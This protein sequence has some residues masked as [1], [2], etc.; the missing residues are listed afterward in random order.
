MSVKPVLL[1]HPVRLVLPDRPVQPDHP[2][3]LVLPD[4]P[5][6]LVQPDLKGKRAIRAKTVNQG[7]E[8]KKESR[9]PRH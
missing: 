5:D 3:H 1:E 9:V 6:R 7:R 4:L 2:G 8:E